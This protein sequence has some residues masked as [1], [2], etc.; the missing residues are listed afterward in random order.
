MGEC[1]RWN[2]SMHRSGVDAG[3]GG[4]GRRGGRFGHALVRGAGSRK[5]SKASRCTVNLMAAPVTPKSVSAVPLISYAQCHLLTHAPQQNPVCGWCNCNGTTN[6]MARGCR[7]SACKSTCQPGPHRAWNSFIT[8]S[9]TKL[10]SFC[11]LSVLPTA[12]AL[13]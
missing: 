12:G 10:L 13:S 2:A 5:T 7:H 8:I 3:R 1:W 4:S 6:G 9:I 11:P